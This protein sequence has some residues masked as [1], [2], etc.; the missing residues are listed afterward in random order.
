MVGADT[1]DVETKGI[2]ILKNHVV[3]EG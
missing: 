1:L 3:A 2:G